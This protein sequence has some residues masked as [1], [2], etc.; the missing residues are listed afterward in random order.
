MIQEDML[1]LR[2]KE[3]FRRNPKTTWGKNELVKQLDILHDNLN[4]Y[5]NC[6]EG[7]HEN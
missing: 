1:M 5:D 7:E 6:V 2:L 4:Q 3:F